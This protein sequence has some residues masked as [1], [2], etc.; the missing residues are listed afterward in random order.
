ML[1][2]VFK[3]ERCKGC[4][5]C[6]VACP[7]NIIAINKEKLND[8]G[9]YPAGLIAPDECIACGMC[10]IACPDVAIEIKEVG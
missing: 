9:Y 4:S 5:L 8:K 3:T 6:V 1:R 10:V 2:A 7:K